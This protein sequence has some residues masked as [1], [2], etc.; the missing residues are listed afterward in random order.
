MVR[1]VDDSL[2][3]Q[4]ASFN[5]LE[6]GMGKYHTQYWGADTDFDRRPRGGGD[7]GTSTP[8]TFG[9]MI[10]KSFKY[11]SSYSN[12]VIDV[13]LFFITAWNEWNEQAL[14][15]PDDIW[16]FGFIKALR[17]KLQSVPLQLKNFK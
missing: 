7:P 17:Q 13:N 3:V 8:D 9:D 11:M 2:W 15:E 14:L 10:G 6:I 1:S 16:G 4:Y 5:D 12:R